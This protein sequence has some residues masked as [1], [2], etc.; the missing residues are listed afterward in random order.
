MTCVS[1]KKGGTGSWHNYNP[2][3]LSIV[4]SCEVQWPS[5]VLDAPTDLSLRLQH[6]NSNGLKC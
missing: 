6:L 5:R 1:L 3:V 4:F 2:A